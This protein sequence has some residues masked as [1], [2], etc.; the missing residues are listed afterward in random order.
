MLQLNAGINERPRGL[1]HRRST[2]RCTSGRSSG[3]MC[4]YHVV[5]ATACQAARGVCHVHVV[6]LGI[7]LLSVN[8]DTCHA[9][10][11]AR[12]LHERSTDAALDGLIVAEIQPGRCMAQS[13]FQCAAWLICCVILMPP[14]LPCEDPVAHVLMGKQASGVLS[15]SP[16]RYISP[17]FSGR[18][19]NSPIAVSADVT[20]IL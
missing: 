18:M 20:L 1:L 12:I 2:R 19:I 13:F 17:H 8:Q 15:M 9:T 16:V 14:M 6:A 11:P 4:V 5:H 10:V 7:L 3:R